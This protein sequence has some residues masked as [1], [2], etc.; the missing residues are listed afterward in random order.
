MCYQ[1]FLIIK[2]QGNLHLII[3]RKLGELLKITGIG[4]N[5]SFVI[6]SIFISTYMKY[7]LSV[8]VVK[9]FVNSLTIKSY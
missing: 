2:L 3:L 9:Y 8:K 5:L 4:L 6:F 7:Y 1:L